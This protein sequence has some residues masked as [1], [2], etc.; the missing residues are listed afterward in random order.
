MGGLVTFSLTQVWLLISTEADASQA[1]ERPS[2]TQYVDY[3]PK[4]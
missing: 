3:E 4:K 1:D 2:S